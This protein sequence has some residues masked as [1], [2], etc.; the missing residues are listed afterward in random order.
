MVEDFTNTVPYTIQNEK[1]S[2]A[3]LVTS[4]AD[5]DFESA[6][7]GVVDLLV[8]VD[9]WAPWCGPCKAIAP[10]LEEIAEDFKDRVRVFKMN[11]DDNPHTPVKYQVRS[12]PTLTLFF[13]GQKLESKIGMQSRDAL[14]SWLEGKIDELDL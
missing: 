5:E 4:I 1:K 3:E 7:I 10:V 9:F 6:V 2:S 12:I 13:K 8:L 14:E 11:I